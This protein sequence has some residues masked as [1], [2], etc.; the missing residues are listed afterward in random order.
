M[1]EFCHVSLATLDYNRGMKRMAD[2]LAQIYEKRTTFQS[3]LL[4]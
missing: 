4:T 3:G 2:V 1:S